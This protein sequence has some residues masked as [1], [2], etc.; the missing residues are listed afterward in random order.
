MEERFSGL[1]DSLT[2][3]LPPEAAL[4]EMRQVIQDLKRIPTPFKG[5]ATAWQGSKRARSNCGKPRKRDFH[6]QPL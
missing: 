5:L 2:L 1:T 3:D 6:L 4:D